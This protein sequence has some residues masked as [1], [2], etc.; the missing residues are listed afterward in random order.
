MQA[1]REQDQT[2]QGELTV[3]EVDV[4]SRTPAQQH[5]DRRRRGVLSGSAVAR[6][7]RRRWV[8]ASTQPA[9]PCACRARTRTHRGSASPA[10]PTLL[11][12]RRLLGSSTTPTVTLFARL[13]LLS[14]TVVTL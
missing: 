3:R 6:R 11:S 2:R 10:L 1:T 7:V 14:S 4:R 9:R 8:R 5:R 12:L 13:V